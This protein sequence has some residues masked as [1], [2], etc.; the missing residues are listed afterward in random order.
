MRWKAWTSAAARAESWNECLRLLG[1]AER[2]RDETGYRWRF[3]FEERSVASARAEALAALGDAAYVAEAAGRT[4]DWRDAAAYVCRVCGDRKRPHH[5][6]ASLTPTELQVVAL[7]SEGLTNPQIAE[8][9][10]MGRGT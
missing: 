5:G 6:W 7:V 1:A 8:R 10:L 9:L 3:G 2:L 4:L